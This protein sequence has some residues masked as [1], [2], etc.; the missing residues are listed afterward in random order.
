M[1]DL[2][3]RIKDRREEL[4]MTQDELS[5]AMGYTSRSS[6]AKIE[7]GSVDI[8]QSKISAFANVLDTSVAWLMGWEEKPKGEGEPMTDDEM[9]LLEDYR[10]LSEQGK[11]FVRQTMYAACNTYK[12]GFG[13]SGVGK[14]EMA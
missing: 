10:S 5:Q 3:K 13:V 11:E 2:Y 12:K 4:G 14:R 7:S 8:P 1:T 6:I 9:K